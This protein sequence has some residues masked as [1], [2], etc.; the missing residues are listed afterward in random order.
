M[1]EFFLEVSCLTR[2]GGF[3]ATLLLPGFHSVLLAEPVCC[4]W[5]QGCYCLPQLSPSVICVGSPPS[6]CVSL[7]PSKLWT[8][9]WNQVRCC[10]GFAFPKL[11]K[12]PEPQQ[13]LQGLSLRIT[14]NSYLDAF[15]AV[16]EQFFDWHYRIFVC[17][18]RQTRMRVAL[19]C[20]KTRQ[21]FKNL[22]YWSPVI[23]SIDSVAVHGKTLSLSQAHMHMHAPPCSL[24]HSLVY[25]V[26]CGLLIPW[27]WECGVFVEQS[28]SC[29]VLQRGLLRWWAAC[30]IPLKTASECE[31]LLF[32]VN[33]LDMQSYPVR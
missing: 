11:R 30:K 25:V 26:P 12:N 8:K 14:F 7:Q 6:L 18:S 27:A 21:L 22:T 29:S 2:E 24:P 13:R 4:G 3:S 28:V 20:K 33:M 31:S 5:R 9:A 32:P 15:L 16:A 10:L 19:P 23:V 1:G 17:F